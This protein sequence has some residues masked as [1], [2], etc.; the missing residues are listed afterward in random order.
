MELDIVRESENE[1]GPS[2]IKG[3]WRNVV[4][5]IKGWAPSLRFAILD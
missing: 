1:V 3:M 4:F 2:H 5:K